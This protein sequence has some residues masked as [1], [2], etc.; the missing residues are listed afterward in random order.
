VRLPEISESVR[1]LQE[2]VHSVMAYL[3]KASPGN[4][5][6]LRQWDSSAEQLCISRSSIGLPSQLRASRLSVM[7]T[8]ATGRH[9]VYPKHALCERRKI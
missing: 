1:L 8:E 6:P 9:A 2:G 4:R 7:Y 3:D 5:S